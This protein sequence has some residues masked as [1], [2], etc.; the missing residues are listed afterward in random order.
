[1]LW[2]VLDLIELKTHCAGIRCVTKT[3][4]QIAGDPASPHVELLAVCEV[5]GPC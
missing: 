3:G 4:G 2:E 1:M 5:G